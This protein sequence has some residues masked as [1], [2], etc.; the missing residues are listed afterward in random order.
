MFSPRQKDLKYALQLGFIAGTGPF[1]IQYSAVNPARPSREPLL[2]D[3]LAYRLEDG[4][5]EG[6]RFQ[7]NLYPP[8]GIVAALDPHTFAVLPVPVAL[9]GVPFLESKEEGHSVQLTIY[10]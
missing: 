10:R 2:V 4:V 6:R 8:A 7:S 3:V 1:S 5:F 9:A